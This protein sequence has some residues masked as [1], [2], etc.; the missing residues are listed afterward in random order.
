MSD[1]KLVSVY[2]KPE[3]HAAFK[4]ACKKNDVSMAAKLLEQAKLFT[5]KENK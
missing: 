1:K 3:D 4:K 5:K 2:F